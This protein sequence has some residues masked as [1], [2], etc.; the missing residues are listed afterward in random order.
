M[1]IFPPTRQRLAQL[2]ML[3]ALDASDLQLR[4]NECGDWRIKGRYG[5]IY[6]A[7]SHD[8][9]GVAWYAFF[10]PER[11]SARL[12]SFAKKVFAPFAK[13]TQDGDEE[14]AFMIDHLPTPQEAEIIRK[15]FGIKHRKRY[16]TAPSAD[17]LA[18]YR[19]SRHAGQSTAQDARLEAAR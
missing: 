6:A 18:A 5:H 11:S 1:D 16:A 7:P 4:R 13:V 15:C 19:A 9:Q 8:L 2:D 10:M 14:G 3:A 12:W 17:G